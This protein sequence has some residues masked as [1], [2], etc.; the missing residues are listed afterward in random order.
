MPIP[1]RHSWQPSGTE[2]INLFC[3]GFPQPLS[4]ILRA[5]PSPSPGIIWFKILGHGGREDWWFGIS[6][7]GIGTVGML[8]NFA[9]AWMVAVLTPPPPPTIQA[10]VDDIRIP[11]GAGA[12]H[13]ISGAVDPAQFRVLGESLH[14]E[15]WIPQIAPRQCNTADAEFARFA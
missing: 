15:C 4:L 12:A 3:I 11:R 7:E 2:T 5:T 8:L 14:G 9:V 10:L 6:P 1:C 13:E